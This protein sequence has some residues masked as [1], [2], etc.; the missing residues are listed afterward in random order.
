MTNGPPS[1]GYSE[2]FRGRVGVA[3]EWRQKRWDVGQVG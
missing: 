2:S 1:L 3:S